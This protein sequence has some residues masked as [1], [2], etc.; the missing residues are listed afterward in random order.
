MNYKKNLILLLLIANIMFVLA[1]LFNRTIKEQFQVPTGGCLSQD[2]PEFPVTTAATTPFPPEP[3]NTENP[4]CGFWVIFI[5]NDPENCDNDEKVA[6]SYFIHFYPL[7]LESFT[8]F[9]ED[10]IYPIIF[11]WTAL[12]DNLEEFP[13]FVLDDEVK[14]ANNNGASPLLLY[15]NK[16]SNIIK[17]HRSPDNLFRLEA[18]TGNRR[19]SILNVDNVITA[20]N[21][22]RAVRDTYIND[23]EDVCYI[24]LLT[25]PATATTT[26]GANTPAT[27][28]T[29]SGANTPATATTISG[30]NTPANANTPAA[31]TPAATT[32][33]ATTPAAT[34]PP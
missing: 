18:G 33:A 8:T 25:T 24:D 1:L 12:N 10:Y 11:T 2:G 4:N 6:K 17:L 26:S 3:Y 5:V 30:A 20:D 9:S 27:A 14:T 21:F 15:K 29:T 28:T 32:P 23:V 22:L 19:I 13:E 16:Y 34:T 31:T 7:L